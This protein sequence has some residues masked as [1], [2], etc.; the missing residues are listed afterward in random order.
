MFVAVLPPMYPYADSVTSYSGAYYPEQLYAWSS[1]EEGWYDP[2]QNLSLPKHNMTHEGDAFPLATFT[3]GPSVQRRPSSTYSG[4]STPGLSWRD[5]SCSPLSCVDEESSVPTAELISFPA[6]LVASQ[7]QS[8]T[9]PKSAYPAVP[10]DVAALYAAQDEAQTQQYTAYHFAPGPSTVLIAPHD[11]TA[12]RA[13]LPSLGAALHEGQDFYP[14]APAAQATSSIH[15]LSPI[16]SSYID[17]PTA[18]LPMPELQH[19]KP[20]R[21]YTPEWQ[22]ATNFDMDEFVKPVSHSNGQHPA[23]ESCQVALSEASSLG[24]ANTYAGQDEVLDEQPPEE[25]EIID[26]WGVGDQGSCAQSQLN[27]APE[28]YAWSHSFSSAATVE[29]PQ[30]TTQQ[31]LPQILPSDAL[32]YQPVSSSVT[33]GLW[34]D[35]D[36]RSYAYPHFS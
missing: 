14:I 34:T 1:K 35:A 30:W 24:D 21:H 18:P 4:L 27:P 6:D 36:R 16:A 28:G 22:Y 29:A 15:S 13:G 10:E 3:A 17:A 26:D 8:L 31:V 25:M 19:P 20:V 2:W 23:V 12:W 9:S 32:L 5:S 11:L 7:T 33:S